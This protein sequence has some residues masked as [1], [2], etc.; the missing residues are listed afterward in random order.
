[1]K[2]RFILLLLLVL[3]SGIAVYWFTPTN[4]P[5]FQGKPLEAWLNDLVATNDDPRAVMAIQSI[6]TNAVPCLLEALSSP[7]G[8]TSDQFYD[9]CNLWLHHKLHV[10]KRPIFYPAQVRYLGAILG[11]KKLGPIAS[12]AVP[13]LGVLLTNPDR[14][15]G[16]AV[17]LASIGPVA[18][19]ALVGALTNG[20]P[21][22]RYH[23]LIG[24]NHLG[25]DA[26][27]A[28]PVVMNYIED[29]NQYQGAH[30]S[31]QAIFAVGSMGERASMAVPRL[32]ALL[33][34]ADSEVRIFA[35]QSLH[36]IQAKPGE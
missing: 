25:V 12:N 32:S 34:N 2:K 29:T 16:A 27:P 8:P 10:V 4:Q 19:P 33:T 3:I 28:L 5:A 30:V 11:F 31:H 23:A 1:V 21:V 17:S 36:R 14:G 13:Q 35:T 15:F 6:G 24:L 7:Y 22:A 18:L 9:K 20:S 26:A